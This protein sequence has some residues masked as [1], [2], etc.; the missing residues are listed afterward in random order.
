VR[1]DIAETVVLKACS[2]GRI[3]GSVRGRLTDESA[4]PIGRLIVHP[5]RRRQGIATRMM[6]ELETYFPAVAG[7]ELF[8]GEKST[9]NIRLYRS[10]GYEEVR[11]EAHTAKITIIRM[12]K[13]GA[14]R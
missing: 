8:T 4:C 3:V 6:R 14:A 1:Q 13:G 12:R 10:L 5:D 9:G 2:A 7:F 11:R